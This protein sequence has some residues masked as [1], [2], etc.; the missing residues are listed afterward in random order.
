MG[1]NNIFNRGRETE[2]ET[3]T[4]L[5]GEAVPAKEIWFKPGHNLT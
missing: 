4:R 2:F 3:L 1:V 5:K